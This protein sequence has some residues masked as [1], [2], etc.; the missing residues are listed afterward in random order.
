MT[1]TESLVLLDYLDDKSIAVIKLNRP[2]RRNALNKAM[3]QAFQH[4][5]EVLKT[6]NTLRAVILSGNGSDF[7]AG[8]DLEWMKESLS[9]TEAENIEDASALAHLLET[10]QH[11]PIPTIAVVEGAVF[12]GGLGLIACCDIVLGSNT[13]RCCFSEVKLGLV[14]AIIMPFVAQAMSLRGMQRY[15]LTA[16]VFDVAQAVQ[17]GLIHQVYSE[18]VLWTEA[19]VFARSIQ[20]NAPIAVSE[21]KALLCQLKRGDAK[22]YTALVKKMVKKIAAVRVGA[23]AQEGMT[24]FFEKRRP[25]WGAQ[26]NV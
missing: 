3:I 20:Q 22:A 17:S 6:V 12:G 18:K 9:Y 16:E 26:K 7:C 1:A 10:L 5:L 19:M 11:F 2:L 21:T 25:I 13:V 8:A 24:A 4:S 23:E 15:C 14:P